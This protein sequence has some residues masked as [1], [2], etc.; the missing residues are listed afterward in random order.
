MLLLTENLL[1]AAGFEFDQI[2]DTWVVPVPLRPVV[3]VECD[4]DGAY[5][6][7]ALLE[8]HALLE[9]NGVTYNNFAVTGRYVSIVGLTEA[10]VLA[11]A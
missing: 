8:I 1:K 9:A 10:A 5:I 7:E 11:L 6:M 3:T 4:E 2:E